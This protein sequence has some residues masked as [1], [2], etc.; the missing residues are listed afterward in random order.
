MLYNKL[1]NMKYCK[2]MY[3]TTFAYSFLAQ[4]ES[5]IFIVHCQNLGAN[6]LS[7]TRFCITKRKT[8]SQKTPNFKKIKA[9][10]Y[11]TICLSKR[12]QERPKGGGGEK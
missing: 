2:K 11:L 4:K 10:S 9:T 6:T 8:V 1:Q 12:A 7:H 5:Y 3:L